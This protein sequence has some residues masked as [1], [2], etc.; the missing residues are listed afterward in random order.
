MQILHLQPLESGA[1]LN[2]V[3]AQITDAVT[4]GRPVVVAIL[5]TDQSIEEISNRIRRPRR[6][7]S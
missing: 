3:L 4:T 2:A 1:P 6:L 5:N 7:P